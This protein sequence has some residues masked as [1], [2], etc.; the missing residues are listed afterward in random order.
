MNERDHTNS[1]LWMYAIGPKNPLVNLNESDLTES[2]NCV[3]SWYGVGGTAFIHDTELIWPCKVMVRSWCDRVNLWYGVDAIGYAA[4]GVIPQSHSMWFLSLCTLYSAHC[5]QVIHLA[6]FMFFVHSKWRD[7][8][9][10]QCGLPL[11]SLP[12]SSICVVWAAVGIKLFKSP[13]IHQICNTTLTD[14]LKRGQ[15]S[16][17]TKVTLRDWCNSLNSPYEVKKIYIRWLWP[18]K[19]NLE[20]I[21]RPQMVS[22]DLFMKAH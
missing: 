21:K 12:L 13:Q 22:A 6:D 16:K 8:L 4:G 1:V 7:L 20:V 17:S 9:F 2:T 11:L 14:D 3:Y 19:V 15:I 5:T 18:I 10:L